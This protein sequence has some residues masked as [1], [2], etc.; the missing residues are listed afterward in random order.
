MLDEYYSLI[1]R[2]Y[3]YQIPLNELASKGKVK[4]KVYEY[5]AECKQLTKAGRPKARQ[6]WME[7]AIKD[8]LDPDVGETL[9]YVNVGKK[10][11]D[12]DIKRV[13]HY[14]KKS[15]SGDT[16]DAVSIIE[17]DYRKYKKEQEAMKKEPVDK[18][19]YIKQYFPDVKIKNEIVFNSYLLPSSL[20][21]SN[22]PI[23]CKDGQEYNVDKY[24]DKLN[25]KTKPLLVCFSR[26]IRDRILITNPSDRPFFTKEQTV[27]VSGEPNHPGDQ[28]RYEDLMSMED[29]EIKFWRAHPEFEIPY[30]KECGMDWDKIVS[31]YD[32]RK[33][34]EK[35]L[36]LDIIRAQY[37]KIINELTSEE[38]ISFIEDGKLPSKLD[39][40]V[41]I[42]PYSNHLLSKQYPDIVLGTINDLIEEDCDND[43]LF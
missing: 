1:E 7:L 21:E 27:L 5:I 22:E 20:I 23:Y 2:I 31:E 19:A 6:A 9:Y 35:R 38:K 36:G 17:K 10:K 18:D 26:E 24:I 12:S 25:N 42:D 3:N 34:E 33:A 11:G 37:E 39:K 28:D 43:E 32:N 41:S 15:V 40:I 4:K 16:F 13:T 30:L 29:K 8:G 14:Y